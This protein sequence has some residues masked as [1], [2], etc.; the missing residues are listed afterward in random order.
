MTV[1]GN[2]KLQNLTTNFTNSGILNINGNVEVNKNTLINTGT[3]NANGTSFA[4]NTNANLENSGTLN[5]ESE[6]SNA[7]ATNSQSDLTNNGTIDVT[8][9]I[10]VNSGSM[11]RNNCAMM[12][13]GTFNI[14][15]GDFELHSGYLKGAEAIKLNQNNSVKIFDGSMISTV[16]LTMNSGGVQGSGTLNS[17]LVTGTFTIYNNNKVDGAIEAATDNLNITNGGIPDHFI[18]GATVV[19][20]GGITNYIEAG[21]CNPDGIGEPDVVDTDNDGVPDEMDDYPSDPYR[22]YNNYFPN[23]DSHATIM[24]E[25]LWPSTGDYDFNDLVVGVYGNEVTNANNDVVEI[26]INFDVKAVGASFKNGFGWQF[27]NLTPSDIQQV[28]GAVLLPSGESKIFTNANGTEQGQDSAVIIAVE[29]IENVLNRAG[30]SMFNTVDNGQVG[31]SDLV[32][33]NILFGE[34]TPVSRNLIGPSAYNIFLIKNQNR[35]VEIHLSDRQPTNLMN[36]DLMG[37]V[38]DVS[39]PLS[40]TYY[41]TASGLPWALL[42]IEPMDYPIEQ[43]P[44][45][46]AFPG[47]ANWAQSGGAI[48]QDWYMNPDQSKIWKP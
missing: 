22:A 38:D 23:E 31:T 39:D 35:D 5:L 37:T 25:D 24:F 27:A 17:I 45:I 41:K 15:S 14:N 1:N 32:T 11:I 21:A 28:T 2:L 47:F 34:T 46:D 20:L 18:N 13:S 43:V 29:N 30:G 10:D 8:G 12:C 4:L 7:L 44:I 6:T 26:K 36:T 48:D 3:I 9:D 40:G 19:G 33:I 16:N 42:V